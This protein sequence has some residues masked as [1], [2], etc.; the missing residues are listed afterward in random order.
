MF[1]FLPYDLA[2]PIP[3]QGLVATGEPFRVYGSLHRA[4][5]AARRDDGQLDRVLVLDDRQL[6]RVPLEGRTLDAT[7][8]KIPQ[9]AILNVG[10]EYWRPESV[11]AGGGYVVRRTGEGIE[12]LLIHRRGVWDLPKGKL[13]PGETPER[14]A[15]REVAEEVGI[16][17]ATIQVLGPLPPTVH[18]YVWPKR[19]IYAV[20][21]TH[22]YAMATTAEA[23][24]PEE[25]EGIEAVTYMPWRTVGELVGYESLRHHQAAI[26]PETL[27]I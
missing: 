27:G 8:E 20:K 12:L 2:L 9:S 14:A 25:R 11:E 4:L 22:W 6:D 3:T 23:F 26:D 10:D 15:V 18:G 13:D 16:D 17:E 21:T 19:D 5:D 1:T 24:E 7:V